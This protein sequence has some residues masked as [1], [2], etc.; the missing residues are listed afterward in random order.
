MKSKVFKKFK[1]FRTGHLTFS[2]IT[3]LL[4]NSVVL[5]PCR[6][7]ESTLRNRV[8]VPDFGRYPFRR[9]YLGR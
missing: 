2:G 9:L 3:S 5:K 7:L 8:L 6:L 4:S 1:E